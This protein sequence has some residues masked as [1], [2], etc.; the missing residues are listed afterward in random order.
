MKPVF[1]PLFK[2]ASLM[3]TSNLSKTDKK[4]VRKLN[5]GQKVVPNGKNL[6]N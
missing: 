2:N 4:G 1:K 3:N 5:F 6:L